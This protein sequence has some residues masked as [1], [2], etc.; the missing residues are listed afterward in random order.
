MRGRRTLAWVAALYVAQGLPYGVSAK[1]WPVYFRAHG[2]SLT[3]I[4]LVGLLSLPWSWKP[5]WAPLVDRFGSR[6]QWIVPCLT[7]LA[8]GSAVMPSLPADRIGPALVALLLAFTIASATQDIAIDAWAVQASAGGDL[9]RINGWRASAFR[10][11]V[12]MAGGL[13]LLVAHGLGWRWAWSLTAAVFAA[14]AVGAAFLPEPERP[15]ASPGARRWRFAELARWIFRREMVPIVLFAL[16]YKLGDQAILRMIE[17][18]WLDRGMTLVEIAV[19]ANTL[20]V[21]LTIAGALGGGWFL[22][23]V[24]M[25]RG[26]LWIGVAQGA[27]CLAYAAV[28]AW[29]LPRAALYAAGSLESFAQGLGA[30]ALLAFLTGCCDPANA[31]TEYALLSALFS[32][33][34]EVAGGA[35]GWATDRMG[36]ASFF[37][38]A[39]ALALPSLALLPWLRP[40]LLEIRT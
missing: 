29:T 22:G 21:A 35:S 31:A 9:G 33:S 18:F 32:F 19:V 40:R 27:A 4:G 11:A 26:L 24:G 23:R 8:L 3:D 13:S 5:L 10:V 39:A 17:P 28:A 15:G 34:R 16:L 36:Y 30:A 37:L 25:F 2:V 7:A 12:V 38:F 14:L 20:G 6:R 1:V